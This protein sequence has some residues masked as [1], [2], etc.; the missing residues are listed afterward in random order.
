MLYALNINTCVG[1]I[2][3]VFFYTESLG[4]R[5]MPLIFTIILRIV[6]IL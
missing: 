5:D 4:I 1:L 6:H 2:I 3:G